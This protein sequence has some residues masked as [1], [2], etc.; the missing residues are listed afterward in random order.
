MFRVY[1]I[2]MLDNGFGIMVSGLG[3]IVHGLGLSCYCLVFR[4]YGLGGC[5]VWLRV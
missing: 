2:Y 4:V 3:I 5:G 1:G